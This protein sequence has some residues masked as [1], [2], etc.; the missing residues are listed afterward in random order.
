VL[1]GAMRVRTFTQDDAHIFCDPEAMASE[2]EDMIDLVKVVYPAI[3]YDLKGVIVR[4]ATRP[5]D[6]LGTD[7]DWDRAEAALAEGLRSQDFPFVLAPGEGAFYGPKIEFHITD[8][9]GRTW[10]CGT[11]QLDSQMPARFGL[12]FTGKDGNKHTPVMLHRV[13]LGSMERQ[14]AVL[15]EHHAGKFPLWLAPVQAR[16]LPI[17]GEQNEYG[18]SVLEK[19]LAAGLRAEIDTSNDKVGAKIRLA[20]LARVPY[21]LV[22]GSREAE[23]A[24]VAVREQSGKDLGAMALDAFLGIARERIARKA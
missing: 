24:A 20:T 15:I 21:M 14:I 8:A 10:Q 22:V 7:A 3:G 2:I 11:I 23:T 13:I 9:I 16:V 1:L 12:E 5:K 6:R 4:L 18:K 17:T 19:L